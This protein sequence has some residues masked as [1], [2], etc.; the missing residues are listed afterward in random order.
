[1]EENVKELGEHSLTIK[2]DKLKKFCDLCGKA[3]EFTDDDAVEIS[4]ECIIGSLFPVIMDNIRAF[5]TE[6]YIKGYNKG[7]EDGWNA[8]QGDNGRVLH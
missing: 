2:L 1:M 6:K 3:N 8:N 5:G 4:F 7:F